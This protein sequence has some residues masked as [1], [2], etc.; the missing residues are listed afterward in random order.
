MSCGITEEGLQILYFLQKRGAGWPL[1]KF[2]RIWIKKIKKLDEVLTDLEKRKLI[3]R[4]N[5]GRTDI[6]RIINRNR[7]TKILIAHDKIPPLHHRHSS[8]NYRLK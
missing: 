7:T 1:E 8:P 4:T 5:D 3:L 6:I 2:N